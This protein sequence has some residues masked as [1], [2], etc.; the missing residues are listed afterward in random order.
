[1]YQK[2]S[3]YVKLTEILLFF[4]GNIYGSG[5]GETGKMGT[6]RFIMNLSFSL[7]KFQGSD[8]IIFVREMGARLMAGQQTLNLY[9]EVRLLCAQL[10]PLRKEG[11]FIFMIPVLPAEPEDAPRQRGS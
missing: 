4:N 1:M 11:L 6:F 9:V 2:K 8:K 5:I 7:Y 10:K 3:K